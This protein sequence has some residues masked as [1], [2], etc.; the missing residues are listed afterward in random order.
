[1]S[2]HHIVREK[3]EPALLIMQIEQFDEEYLGQLLEWSPTVIVNAAILDKVLSLG[4]KIDVTFASETES[5]ETQEHIKLIPAGEDTLESAL[6]YLVAEGY[7][8]VNIITNH[9]QAKD[10]LFYVDLIDLVI[11]NH[12]KKIYPI[13]T[14]FS[15]WKPKGEDIFILHPELIHALSVSGL[16][17][18][19]D[20]QYQ[21][22][23]DGFFSFTFEPP[24]IFIAE[25]L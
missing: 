19:R 22:F 10:Y 7:P 8:A 11:F 4:I 16:V 14:G 25:Q 24:F 17:K 23:K 1:M 15:K 6:K 9:F 2:S 3:Q 21:T 18:I 13:K 20:S 5:T 12:D